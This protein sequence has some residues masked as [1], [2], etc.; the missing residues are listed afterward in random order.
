M[1][2]FI[3]DGANV[4]VDG[5]TA[6]EFT[7]KVA[8]AH[9]DV[10]FLRTDPSGLPNEETF[11]YNGPQVAYL[12]GMAAGLMTK[13][14]RI[15]YVNAFDMPLF[16][17]EISAMALGAQSVNPEATVSV[18]TVN[19][20]YDPATVKQASEALIASGVDVLAGS[21]S[22]P[23]NNVAIAEAKQVWAVGVMGDTR[24]YA[25]TMWLTGSIINFPTMLN[26][27]IGRILDGKWEGN[28]VMRF[29]GVPDGMTLAEWGPNVPQEVKDKV[30]AVLQRIIKEGYDPLAGPLYDKEGELVLAQGK[31]FTGLEVLQGVPWLVKG[32]EGLQ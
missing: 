5:V 29:Y 8:E 30:D 10:K 11:W 28:G 12:V 19:S 16:R 20:W 23:A 22:D 2:Q 24:T 3:A 4:I 26:D 27:Q 31:S 7:T 18:A 32:V 13:S 21:V 15:G 1:E 14:N 6:G 17:L 9:P 25:P